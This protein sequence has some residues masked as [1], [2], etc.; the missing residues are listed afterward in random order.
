MS[1]KFNKDGSIETFRGDSFK[2]RVSGIPTNLNYS[3]YY[4][5]QNKDKEKIFTKEEQSNNNSY[6]IFDILKTD[7]ELCVVPEK[8]FKEIYYHAVKLCIDGEEH[9]ATIKGV[10]FGK[11]NKFIVYE[12]QAEGTIDE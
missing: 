5:V 1:V 7:T 4:E 10:E 2:I 8:N 9:T 6:V 12:Q 3:V 11:R